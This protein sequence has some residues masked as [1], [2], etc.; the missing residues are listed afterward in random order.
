MWKAI[1][2]TRHWILPGTSWLIGSGERISLQD[3]SNDLDLDYTLSPQLISYFRIKGFEYL[4]HFSTYSASITTHWRDSAFFRLNGAWKVQWDRFT[5]SLQRLGILLNNREDC[6]HWNFHP[7]GVVT[8]KSAYLFLISE[9]V[10]DG[11]WWWDHRIWRAQAPLK[12]ICFFWLVMNKRILTWDQ[13]CKRG[14][15]GPGICALCKLESEDL[16]HLFIQ[17]PVTVSIWSFVCSD[18]RIQMS[19]NQ[20]TLSLCFDNWIIEHKRHSSLPFFI[21][22]GVWLLRNGII[23]ED[24]RSHWMFSG[25]KILSLYKEFYKE[26]KQA[27]CRKIPA[28]VF[29]FNLIGFFDGAAASGR[30]GSGFVL[31]INQDHFYRGWTGI[32]ECS[33]NLAELFA[34]WSLLYWAHHLKLSC[35]RVFGDSLLV[36]NWLIGKSSIHAKHLIHL[37]YR[38]RELLS[39]FDQ[40]HFQHV[41][42][43]YNLEAD[44]LS[45]KGIGCP[46]GILLIEEIE[47]GLLKSTIRHNIFS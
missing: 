40:V 9:S 3:L 39:H 22:W 19:W 36:I 30:G 10:P 35:F 33:N 20:A 2:D 15:S 31:F 41:Y 42:R 37:C 6:L 4:H 27:I 44:G 1:L 12:I 11:E 7:L 38:I 32:L 13:L 21:C 14:W 46:E 5:S 23:F 34:V 17:C 26:P 43:Q 24:R 8:A 18:L 25:M 47:G 29:D 16:V 45:K 28:I